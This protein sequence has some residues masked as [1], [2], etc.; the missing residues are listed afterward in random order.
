MDGTLGNHFA[1]SMCGL[2]AVPFTLK[3][4]PFKLTDSL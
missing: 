2:K 1:V 3:P 4:V